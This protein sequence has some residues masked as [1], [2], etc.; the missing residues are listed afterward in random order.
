MM[1]CLPFPSI[2][3]EHTNSS[4]L[5]GPQ[6]EQFGLTFLAVLNDG[7]PSILN[8]EEVTKATKTKDGKKKQHKLCGKNMQ[9]LD[10]FLSHE[11]QT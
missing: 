4:Q 3:E 11:L 5:L 7:P 8:R 6:D 1:W 9:V 2:S 10:M